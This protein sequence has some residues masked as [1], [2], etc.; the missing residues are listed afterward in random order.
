MK[1]ILLYIVLSISL[2]AV[3][4][5]S[6]VCRDENFKIENLKM[7]KEKAHA[8]YI[9]INLTEEK[10]QAEKDSTTPS[11]LLPTK[12]YLLVQN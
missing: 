2:T 12:N 7:Y 9:M 11:S 5:E 3:A 4:Q 8:S 10:Q 1:T 6:L